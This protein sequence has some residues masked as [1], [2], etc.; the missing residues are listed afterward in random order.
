[1]NLG[2]GGGGGAGVRVNFI[3]KAHNHPCKR[4]NKTQ[5]YIPS[6]DRRFEGNERM[7]SNELE[8]E[9]KDGPLSRR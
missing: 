2:R 6:R 8:Q 5:K 1:M 9:E 4:R 3:Y 7:E